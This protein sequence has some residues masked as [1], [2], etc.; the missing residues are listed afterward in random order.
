MLFVV[1]QS[2]VM[3]RP[4]LIWLLHRPEQGSWLRKYK[5]NEVEQPT[6]GMKRRRNAE[7]DFPNSVIRR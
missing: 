2:M 4:K 1:T 3:A 6:K 5:L 7:A